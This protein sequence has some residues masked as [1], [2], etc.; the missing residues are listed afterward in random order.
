MSTNVPNLKQIGGGHRKTLVDLTWHDPHDEDLVCLL[1]VNI[2]GE[3]DLNRMKNASKLD[4][5]RKY[6]FG[7][8]L[9]KKNVVYIIQFYYNPQHYVFACRTGTNLSQEPSHKS[10]C[11]NFAAEWTEEICK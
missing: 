2:S 10:I 7:K 3:M 11:S 9:K 6:Y 8:Y 1:Q 4:L 5:C